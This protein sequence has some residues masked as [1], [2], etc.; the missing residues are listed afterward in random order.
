[1]KAEHGLGIDHDAV[2][3]ELDDGEDIGV[4]ERRSG[5]GGIGDV[6]G[7]AGLDE[8]VDPIRISL[9]GGALRK[10]EGDDLVDVGGAGV[11]I[12]R[13]DGREVGDGV[14][15]R[16]GEDATR[17]RT[18]QVERSFVLMVFLRREVWKRG[19]DV[20]YRI[21]VD[22]GHGCGGNWMCV[23][24]VMRDLSECRITL[25]EPLIHLGPL[26]LV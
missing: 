7:S 23:P 11:L 17:R 15:E 24:A 4:M 5:G 20:I 14:G 18:R 12:E 21:L 16:L 13:L 10:G 19:P 6:D 22:V 25:I 9:D 2:V 26:D 1:L 8:E 3:E